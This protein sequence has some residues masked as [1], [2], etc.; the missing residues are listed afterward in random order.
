[1]RKRGFTLIELLVVIAIIAILAAI[2]FPV[3]SR[4]REQARQTA[5]LSNAKQIGTALMM[6][7]QD[8]DE[9]FP[10]WIAWCADGNCA[11]G[12]SA[13][14]NSLF[15][16]EQLLPYVKNKDVFKCPSDNRTGGWRET[17]WACCHGRYD[18]SL[19]RSSYGYNETMLNG[20][21]MYWGCSYGCNKLARLIAPAETVILA[22]STDSCFYPYATER[23]KGVGI[24]IAFPNWTNEPAIQCGCPPK[25]VDWNYA[26]ANL[27]RHNGGNILIF[28]DGHAKW[29]KADQIRDKRFGGTLRFCDPSLTSDGG[30]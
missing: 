13:S 12:L 18:N 9:S 1:M 27:A 7:A 29:Y 3:F 19:P 4:A 23:E 6:Y 11:N 30:Y 2:L 21:Y 10:F 22:D 26:I 16:T 5:C 8:W 20:G 14:W 28:G 15:W 25:V 17:C 24:R